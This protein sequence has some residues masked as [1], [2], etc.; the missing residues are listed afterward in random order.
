MYNKS[1]GKQGWIDG[2]VSLKQACTLHGGGWSHLICCMYRLQ[3]SARKIAPADQEVWAI[4]Q[5]VTVEGRKLPCS[6]CYRWEEA[7]KDIASYNIGLIH[8]GRHRCLLHSLMSPLS[9]LRLRLV[10]GHLEHPS[11]SVKRLL[12]AY[13]YDWHYS[14]WCCR[15]LFPESQ[16]RLVFSPAVATDCEVH[17]ESSSLIPN[18][19][20]PHTSPVAQTI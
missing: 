2:E 10:L 5:W 13:P 20:Q 19:M 17:N 18:R 4:W 16:R 3:Q 11:S 12:L 1:S 7:V 9:F 6:Q 8:I 15:Q 14:M